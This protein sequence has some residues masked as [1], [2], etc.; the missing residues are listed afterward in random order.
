MAVLHYELGMR[1]HIQSPRIYV[2]FN[3]DIIYFGQINF[4]KGFT[5]SGLIRDV[6]E[7]ELSKICFLG[8][9]QDVWNF[10]PFCNGHVL[11]DFRSLKT[12]TLAMERPD[13]RNSYL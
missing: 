3:R 8:M 2:D 5:L 4:D 1:S 6:P 12:L 13:V 9:S 10:K 7:S 11:M